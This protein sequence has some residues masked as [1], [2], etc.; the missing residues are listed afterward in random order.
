MVYSFSVGM[1]QKMLSLSYFLFLLF[2]ALWNDMEKFGGLGSHD[3]MV[4][5]EGAG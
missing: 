2:V 5:E 3:Y 1:T 4:T